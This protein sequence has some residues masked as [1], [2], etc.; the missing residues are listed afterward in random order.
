MYVSR[1][2]VQ[3]F[4]CLESVDV[5]LAA[6]FNL[7]V[8]D[9]AS[10]KTSFLEAFAY[11]ARGRSFRG[12]PL[13]AIVKHGEQDFV[14]RAVVQVDG[15][16]QNIAVQNGRN[17]LKTRVGVEEDAG[18]AE[19][20]SALPL[21][22]IDP[23][24]HELVAGGPD[25]RRRFLDWVAFHVEQGFVTA[26]RQFRR[27]LK[28]RNALLRQGGSAASLRVWDSQYIEAAM[29]VDAA[30]RRVLETLRPYFETEISALLNEAVEIDYAPGWNEAMDLGS[31]L[32]EGLARDRE[33]GIT[34][35]GPHRAELRLRLNE[36]QAK[37]LVSRGQQKLLACGLILAGCGVVQGEG[38]RRLVLLVDDLAAELDRGARQRLFDRCLATNA[39][40]VVTSLERDHFTLP[41]DAAV[42]HVERGEL[43][44][45]H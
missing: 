29:Q 21:Q 40:L 27:V 3:R 11:L 36:R 31:A 15:H 28:Q 18:L 6:D 19:L 16:G 1:L 35:R 12:A 41:D 26:W 13:T 17:G 10:G 42:F 24:V 8:G 5:T 4:R 20:A 32:E 44:P 45:E 2:Q 38:G 9:N 25:A 7:I 34:H 23:E 39:Q 33:D 43:R 14:V 22:I 30:R 37:R